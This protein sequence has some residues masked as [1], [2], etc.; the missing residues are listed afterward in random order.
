MG[1]EWSPSCHY[2]VGSM[3]I[4]TS[5]GRPRA[6]AACRTAG[7]DAHVERPMVPRIPIRKRWEA[8]R[9]F[10]CESS[11]SII[12]LPALYRSQGWTYGVVRAHHW[13]VEEWQLWSMPWPR[14]HSLLHPK[15][16]NHHASSLRVR[17]WGILAFVR[18]ILLFEPYITPAVSQMVLLSGRLLLEARGNNTCAFCIRS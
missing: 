1:L 13:K 4:A 8:S 10:S 5:V 3:Q 2:T 12:L 7:S 18:R 15:P 14:S 11:R 16:P 17:I 6:S 9:P